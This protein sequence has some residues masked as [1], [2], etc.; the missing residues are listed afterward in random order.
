[1]G[2][3]L[4]AFLGIPVITRVMEINHS[5]G[6]VW[7]LKTADELEYRRIRVRLP[8]VITVTRELNNPRA[9]SFSG[10]LKAKQKKLNILGIKDLAIAE[11]FTGSKGS[12]TTTKVSQVRTPQSQRKVEFLTGTREEIADQLIQKLKVYGFE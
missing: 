5:L 9:L 2:P 11:E 4:A 12:P 6:L 3:E 1:V 8:A 7:E 10:V